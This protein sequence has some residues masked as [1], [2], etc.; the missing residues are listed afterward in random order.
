MKKLISILVFAAVFILIAGMSSGSEIVT[1]GPKTYTCTK[2]LVYF[3]NSFTTFPGPGTL[4][5]RNG[6]GNYKDRVLLALIELNGKRVAPFLLHAGATT[7]AVRLENINTLSIRLLGTTG[8]F[9]TI[10]I[11]QNVQAP[12]VSISADPLSIQ[13][14]ES[15][16]LSWDTTYSD[17][18]V[19]DPDIGT[20]VPVGSCAVSPAGTTTY[21]I[22]AVG[23]GGTA[24]GSVTV[25]VTK[26]AYDPPTV[27]LSPPKAAITKGES[28]TISWTSEGALNA[29]IDNSVGPVPANGSRTVTSEHTTISTLT[30][31]GETG[32]ASATAEISVNGAPELP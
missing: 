25:E 8:S 32:S 20:V 13:K 17:Y 1:F 28:I 16:T 3:S 30:V 24:S 27:D 7:T 31:S 23:R 22:S 26:S 15:S 4:T 29:Y 14:G 5:I 18:C 6:S 21:H 9:I 12:T 10:T 2:P 11:T 19:I